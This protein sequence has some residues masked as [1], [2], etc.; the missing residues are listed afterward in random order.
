ME[1]TAVTQT[2]AAILDAN[3]A[4]AARAELARQFTDED[5]AVQVA[6][7]DT[8]HRQH[9]GEFAVLVVNCTSPVTFNDTFAK[10][11]APAFPYRV[12]RSTASDFGWRIVLAPKAA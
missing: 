11:V 7:V 1:T 8:A 4:R 12:T 5:P 9:A 2:P 10:L 6:G 3:E